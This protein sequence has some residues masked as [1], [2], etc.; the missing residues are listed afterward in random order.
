MVH[1]LLTSPF[2][3]SEREAYT[4]QLHFDAM[5]LSSRS[6]S[7]GLE[8]TRRLHNVKDCISHNACTNDLNMFRRQRISQGPHNFSHSSTDGGHSHHTQAARHSWPTSGRCGDHGCSTLEVHALSHT[9]SV[10]GSRH[11]HRASTRQE[12]VK[13]IMVPLNSVEVLSAW[14]TM[15]IWRPPRA[16]RRKRVRQ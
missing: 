13:E 16:G 4:G 9:L 6:I 10:Q 14:S 2:P 5:S 3:C 8:R 15:E 11:P 1:C 7:R 12:K